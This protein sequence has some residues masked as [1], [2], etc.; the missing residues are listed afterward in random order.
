MK[1]LKVYSITAILLLNTPTLV[2]CHETDVEPAGKCSVKLLQSSQSAY[3]N[4]QENTTVF[5]IDENTFGVNGI[6]LNDQ[7]ILTA[8]KTPIKLHFA[9]AENK[10]LFENDV[11][12]IEK[13]SKTKLKVV[14]KANTSGI[15]REL[16]INLWK[17]NCHSYVEILQSATTKPPKAS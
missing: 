5:V 2:G 12:L 4:N 6:I 1:D 17:G 13:I 15:N 16:R 7:E 10:V 9:K 11:V 3:I 8:K 14:T